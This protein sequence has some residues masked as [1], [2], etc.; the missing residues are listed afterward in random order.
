[1]GRM[2]RVTVFCALLFS[3]A[4]SDC[5]D[6]QLRVGT[7][8]RKVRSPDSGSEKPDAGENPDGSRPHTS[9]DAEIL[10]SMDGD[11][12]S[13]CGPR[14]D[15]RCSKAVCETVGTSCVRYDGQTPV[16]ADALHLCSQA[17]SGCLSLEVRPCQEQCWDDK[18][19]SKVGRYY[20]PENETVV[21]RAV[22]F[23][24]VGNLFAT[25]YT[26]TSLGGRP[27]KGGQD[28]FLTK[29]SISGELLWSRTWGTE[30][31][32]GIYGLALSETSARLALAGSLNG[33]IWVGV[34]DS[35]NGETTL[36]ERA[37]LPYGVARAV[38]YGP[39]HAVFVA[40]Y[41]TGEAFAGQTS[42]GGTDAFLMRLDPVA[43]YTAWARQFGRP[44]RLYSSVKAEF[45]I[46]TALASSASNLYVVGAYNMISQYSPGDAD[47][48]L[49]VFSPSGAQAWDTTL[50]YGGAEIATKVAVDTL[51]SSTVAGL[52]IALGPRTDSEFGPAILARYS[53]EGALQWNKRDPSTVMADELALDADHR[54][55]ALSDSADVV[56]LS[57]DDGSWQ[58][59]IGSF[60]PFLPVSDTLVPRG[61]GLALFQSGGKVTRVA[62][63]GGDKST[64]FIAVGT[65][66]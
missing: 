59:G 16:T 25:G 46:A 32:D 60:G 4:E 65:P 28:A 27:T 58:G 41:I 7:L 52:A 15:E 63:S 61:G 26:T 5:P 40:G 51:G 23:D 38:I 9:T 18:R 64:K 22:K 35:N 43:G 48:F 42:P 20:W 29:W 62:T 53:S 57:S 39:D 21:V 55:W 56:H 6:G 19:C 54:L 30:V 44:G 31:D 34:L 36:W 1:V 8:C 66:E 17:P 50:D 2:L 3:C 37:D 45:D 24:A 14:C 13:D 49:T 12:Q 10:S 47:A 33:R 11:S